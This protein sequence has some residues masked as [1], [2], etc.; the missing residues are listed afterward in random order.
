MLAEVDPETFVLDLVGPLHDQTHYGI[1]FTVPSSD[2]YATADSCGAEVSYRHDWVSAGRFGLQVSFRALP[3][4]PVKPMPLRHERY[5]EW[6]GIEPPDV[7][8]LDLHEVI[9]EKIRAAAQ[10]TR[11]RDLYDLYQFAGQRFDRDLV[12]RIA[13]I[14]CWE[15]RYAFDPVAFLSGAAKGQYD[16]SDLR[17]LVRR[18]AVVAP[19]EI[20]RG[21]QQG[22]AFLGKLTADEVLLAGDAY[23]RQR[24]AYHRLVE[25]LKQH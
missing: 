10:R 17:R 22:Y 12:R 1:T 16:W 4:L 8:T 6:L 23:G 9:G 18:S 2:Y 13:V 21:V 7:P 20:V 24:Q 5:F 11:V 3:L 25:S 15:T 14:K 19:E